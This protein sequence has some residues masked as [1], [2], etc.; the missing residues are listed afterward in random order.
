MKAKQVGW[1]TGVSK[2]Y[3]LSTLGGLYEYVPVQ[4]FISPAKWIEI[5][6]PGEVSSFSFSGGNDMTIVVGGEIYMRQSD[7]R[8]YDPTYT[9]VKFPSLP[10]IPK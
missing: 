5:S 8:K 6:T 3:A 7:G 4:G 10:E 9:W 2:L 1:T